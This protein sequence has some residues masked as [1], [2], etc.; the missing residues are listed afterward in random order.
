MLP[1]VFAAS[2]AALAVAAGTPAAADPVARAS[3]CSSITLGGRAFVF[4]KTGLRCS[5]AKELARY[6]HR[7]HRAP[8]RRWRCSSGSRYR[9]G[10]YCRRPGAS[11]GWHPGD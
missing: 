6:V 4:Y 2:A 8:D 11:F 1:R 7:T 5:R 3:A 10:G 9:T